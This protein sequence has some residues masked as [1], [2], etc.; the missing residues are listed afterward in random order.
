[1]IPS[2]RD[3]HERF[4]PEG[5]VVIGNHYPEF[6]HEEVLEN[7]RAAAQDLNVTYPVVQDN[8]GINW[9][10][11]NNRYWPTH[12]LIDKNG[13]IRYSHIGEGALQETEQ[14]IMELLAEEYP[15]Q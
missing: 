6:K 14:A 13:R 7:V 8:D 12:Y 11:F 1:M 2:L 3:W 5:L 10:A 9:R 4:G 15:P